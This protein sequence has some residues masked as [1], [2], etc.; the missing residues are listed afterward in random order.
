VEQ[1]LIVPELVKKLPAFY[2]A[3]TFTAMLIKALHLHPSC[4]VDLK[5]PTLSNEVLGCELDSQVFGLP[6]PARERSF[7]FFK[8]SKLALGLT[9]STIQ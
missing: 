8:V 3:R 9:Q 6:L 7:P 4:E 5:P 2:G 1:K